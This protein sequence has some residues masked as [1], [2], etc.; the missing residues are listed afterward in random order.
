M[1]RAESVIDVIIRQAGEFFGES[2]IVGLFFRMEA[3]IFQQQRLS[4]L[5]LGRHLFG[6]DAHALRTEAHVLVETELLI[7]QHAQPLGHRFEAH[8]R[9][10]FALGTPQ[11]RGQN[12]FSFAPQRIFDGR[13]S[14]DNTS[15]IGYTAIFREGHIEI[16]PDKYTLVFEVQIFDRKFCHVFKL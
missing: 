3:E 11:M 1:R 6:F 12:D 2:R 15:V 13:Q 10:R 5:Q 7:Q 4:W 9:I 16:H 8:F 14:F